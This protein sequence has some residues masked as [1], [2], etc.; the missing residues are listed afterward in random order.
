MPS[1]W[2]PVYKDCGR[3]ENRCLG[4]V[5]TNAID[6]VGTII[7]STRAAL[8]GSSR[9]TIYW[10][11]LCLAV[12]NQPS[13]QASQSI[14]LYKLYAHSRIIDYKEFQCFNILIT[15]ESNWRVNAINGSH[16]GLGQMRNTK[17][18]DLDGFRQIDWSIR[19]NIHRYKSHCN[20]LKHFLA[21]G[22]H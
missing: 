21:K 5:M 16:Y 10:G 20:T 18:R 8:A 13:A 4:F 9:R 12:L 2:M 19:Y 14:D 11:V 15:K 7:L 6:M 3:H 1:L 17:Y 22:W